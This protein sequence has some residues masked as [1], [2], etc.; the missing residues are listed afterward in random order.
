[1]NLRRCAVPQPA[2]SHDPRWRCAAPNRRRMG[3]RTVV[4]LVVVC[5]SALSTD[6]VGGVFEN[7]PSFNALEAAWKTWKSSVEFKG[8][9]VL[10]EGNAATK[11]LALEG[12][13]G[14][15]A[16]NPKAENYATGVFI[17]LGDRMRYSQ[18]YK[19][20][21]DLKKN[22]GVERFFDEISTNALSLQS[23]FKGGQLSATVIPR[24]D[25]LAGVVVS[26][27]WMLTAFH[28]F[29][30]GVKLD[31]TLK[32]F[33]DAR[34]GI[35]EKVVS[36]SIVKPDASHIEIQ[37]VK[38]FEKADTLAH[39]CRFRTDVVP[40]VIERI[41]IIGSD[42]QSRNVKQECVVSFEDFV[43]CKGGLM[44]RCVRKAF[45]PI[46][47]VGKDRPVWIAD[48]WKS[49]DLGET[50]PTE[51]DFVYIAPEG[52]S[53]VG[54]NAKVPIVDGKYHLDLAD[55]TSNRKGVRYQFG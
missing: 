48:E 26:G 38:T 24:P 33:L 23:E 19:V 20:H 28:P 36:A 32:D 12:R 44:P 52:S 37:V 31:G 10:R 2:I 7:N 25:N 41:E 46:V 11:E 30:A 54:L 22:G 47:P 15:Q 35:D 27:T 5:V 9:Y 51:N 8:E 13:F 49:N 29:S 18:E 3:I 50:T 43:Q 39:H 4:P 45:G 40:P 6:A 53:I 55:Y 17:K 14:S 1:M 16:G 34:P 21:S 42:L